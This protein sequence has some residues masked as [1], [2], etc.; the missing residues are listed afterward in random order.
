MS[1]QVGITKKM[2][3]LSNAIRKHL[4]RS[5][6]RQ[7]VEEVTGANGWIIAYLC[8]N[9]EREVY[10][11]DLEREFGINRST[12]SK[13]LARMEASGLVRRVRVFADDRLKRIVLTEKSKQLAEKIRADNLLTEQKLLQ[14]FTAEEIRQFEDYM[15]RMLKNISE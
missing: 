12:T 14:G 9:E 7:E 5:P 10:Q 13:M 1:Q 11:R 3:M 8:D 15:Q 6:I 2:C 4:S